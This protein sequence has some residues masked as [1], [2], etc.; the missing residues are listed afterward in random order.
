MSSTN[1]RYNLENKLRISKYYTI[2]LTIFI[3]IFYIQRYFSK[4]LFKSISNIN[5]LYRIAIRNGYFS[6]YI[7]SEKF[8]LV[9]E[10]LTNNS[11]N[12]YAT[13]LD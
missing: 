1:K 11:I 3:L 13:L 7:N 9:Q 5:I 10:N 12:I 8:I 4:L 2:K 6:K